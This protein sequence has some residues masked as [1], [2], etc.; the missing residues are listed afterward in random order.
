MINLTETVDSK[1]F[2]PISNGLFCEKIFGPIKNNECSCKLY[3]KI[4]IKNL[5]SKVIICP[6]CHVQIM[7]SSIR[8]YRMG[9]KLINYFIETKSRP[10]WMTITYLPVLP[11][12]LRPIIKLEENVIVTSDLNFLY[13][14]IINSN[15]RTIQLQKMKVAEK[16]I[17]KEKL[18][19]QKSIDRKNNNFFKSFKSLSENI[20]GKHGRIREN[21]L[22]KTVDYSGRSV[23]TVEPNLQINES[24]TLH[25]VGIQA[26]QPKITQNKSIKLHPLV[27]SAFNADFDGDQM[28]IHIPI[29]LKSQ[30]EARTLMISSNNCTSPATGKANILPSQD[31]V[32]GCYF[33]TNDNISLYYLLKNIQRI[34]K[35]KFKMSL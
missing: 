33:L 21:L 23:I 6:N 30:S 34:K 31:M 25:R 19:I 28:G 32:L 18:I 29:S 11:P 2:K 5:E 1:S 10:E 27:C 22:G 35:F 15:N 16:F 13:A 4:R 9:F 20:N 14:K 17:Q 12:E 7:E 24:P 26:F 3:K 8:R